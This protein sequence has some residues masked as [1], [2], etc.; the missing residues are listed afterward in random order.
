MPR[1]ILQAKSSRDSVS[2]LVGHS[3]Q[4]TTDHNGVY[5]Q[6]LWYDGHVASLISFCVGISLQNHGIGSPC[7]TKGWSSAIHI[8]SASIPV[9]MHIA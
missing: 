5:T 4:V 8:T 2:R 9:L 3:E 7:C 6:I 1:N